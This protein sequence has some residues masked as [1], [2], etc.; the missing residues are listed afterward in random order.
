MDEVSVFKG[1]DMLG[2][3]VTEIRNTHTYTHTDTC[4][5]AHTDTHMH[6][7]CTQTF[8]LIVSNALCLSLSNRHTYTHTQTRAHTQYD[9]GQQNVFA[10][11]IW[12]HQTWDN[13][14]PMMT[15][16]PRE[17]DP[18]GWGVHTK[19]HTHTFINRHMY[20]HKCAHFHKHISTQTNPSTVHL[21]PNN[22]TRQRDL[23]HMAEWEFTHG[24]NLVLI[25]QDCTSNHSHTEWVLYLLPNGPAA[26]GVIY[27]CLNWFRVEQLWEF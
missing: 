25:N 17:N 23:S 12:K 27:I 5:S 1:R 4:I 15:V 2:I 24:I 8:L 16:W 3:L 21:I 11:L 18:L 7:I 19:T 10:A 14:D 9:S 20:R 6:K 22:H 13:M 26:Y